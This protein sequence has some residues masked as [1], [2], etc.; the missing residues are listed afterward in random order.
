MRFIDRLFKKAT[1][2]QDDIEHMMRRLGKGK[3]GRV[4]KMA[5]QPSRDEYMKTVG[6]TSLGI[7]LLGSLGFV[8]Y[9]IWT[10]LPRMLW[11]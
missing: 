10:E 6:I 9:L 7:V 8:I 5:R 11:P 2:L 4:L 3:Y 1:A